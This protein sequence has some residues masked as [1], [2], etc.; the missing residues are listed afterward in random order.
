[1]AASDWVALAALRRARGI[2]GELA[3]EN[4]GS[5]PERFV[6]GLTGTLLA[7]LESESGRD[8]EVERAWF[9]GD[10]LILKFRGI[11]T[12]T[13]A[14]ILQGRFFCIA[15]DQRPPAPE[16]Q[17]YLSDL[18]GCELV[19]SSDGRRIGEV[20]GYLDLGGPLLLESGEDLM[21]PYVP[22]ICRLV[23]TMAKRIVVELPEGL[24]DL[25]RK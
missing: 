13:E 8:V 15:A 9:H 14:E 12:R 2:R 4:M 16:G 1:L 19:A 7:T 10:S 25:N 11:D 17:V 6:P 5:D 3:A 22:E 20:T 21:I 24:E 18:I 23:D